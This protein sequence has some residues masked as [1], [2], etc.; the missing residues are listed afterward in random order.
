MSKCVGRVK[1]MTLNSDGG[2]GGGGGG[3]GGL[4]VYRS[5]WGV[6]ALLE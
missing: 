5:I 6:M 2:E 3:R 1:N 4:S